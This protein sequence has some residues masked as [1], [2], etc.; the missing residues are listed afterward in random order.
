MPLGSVETINRG[1]GE[2]MTDFVGRKT[3]GVLV[4]GIMDD[5]TEYICKGA[6]R[7]ADEENVNIV[8]FPGKYI[9]RDLTGS[10]DLRYEY[11]YHTVFA[12]AKNEG[13]DALVVAAD[14]IGCFTSQQRI[15]EMVAEYT[16]VP[17]ILC[18]T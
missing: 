3:I 15:R 11:Q 12:Y 14:S 6:K 1:I 5:Y 9:D 2:H 7:A 10:K 17:C 4:S 13:I 16:D 8:I 18:G